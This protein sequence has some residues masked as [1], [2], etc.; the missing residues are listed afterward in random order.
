MSDSSRHRWAQKVEFPP[1]KSERQCI[2][3]EMVLV[4]RHES[5]GGRPVHWKEFYRDEERVHHDA[6]P[7][8]DARLERRLEVAS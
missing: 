7:P 5:E 4:S 6:T 1:Y 3:C 8:C 2:R